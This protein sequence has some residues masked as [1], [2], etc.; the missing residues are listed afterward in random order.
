MA[1]GLE[2]GVWCVVVTAAGF[3]VRVAVARGLRVALQV[4]GSRSEW[5]P[6]SSRR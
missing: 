1:G 4:I 5:S 6:D 2:G 3:W